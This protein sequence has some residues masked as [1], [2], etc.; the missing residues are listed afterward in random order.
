MRVDA[1]DE[2]ETENEEENEIELNIEDSVEKNEEGGGEKG[3]EEGGEGRE[4][5]EDGG[6]EFLRKNAINRRRRRNII[7]SINRLVAIV[8]Y[9]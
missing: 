9:R 5:K 1:E 6:K 2:N 3:G 7:R 4:D 8:L